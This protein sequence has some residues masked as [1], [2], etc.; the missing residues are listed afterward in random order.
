MNRLLT[1]VEVKR[2]IAKSCREYN[3]KVKKLAAKKTK[4]NLSKNQQT[5][6]V[7]SHG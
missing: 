2:E 1:P 5:R 7:S 6:L 4:R 3:R